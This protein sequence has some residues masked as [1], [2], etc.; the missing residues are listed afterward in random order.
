MAYNAE[1][2]ANFEKEK[3]VLER[4]ISESIKTSEDRQ[5][6]NEKFKYEIKNLKSKLKEARLLLKDQQKQHNQQ[7][8]SH[9]TSP[10]QENF[11]EMAA[12]RKENISLKQKLKELTQCLD[13]QEGS[14]KNLTK[15]H[16]VENKTDSDGLLFNQNS[17]CVKIILK[18]Y[19]SCFFESQF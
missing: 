10:S 12:L 5:R 7:V 11:D 1:L 6:D 9:T 17:F 2:L 4:R 8:K 15:R 3:K 16:K 13:E 14:D 18:F 19:I